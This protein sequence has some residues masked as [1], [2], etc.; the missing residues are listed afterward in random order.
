MMEA[1]GHKSAT[2]LADELLGL[3]EGSKR[4]DTLKGGDPVALAPFTAA[5][6]VGS[7]GDILGDDRA[8]PGPCVGMGWG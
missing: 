1:Q 2:A 5:P 4:V 7:R 3:L 6:Q 8:P